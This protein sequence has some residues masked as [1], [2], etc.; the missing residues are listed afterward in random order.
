M[1]GATL[2]K[3]EQRIEAGQS[4]VIVWD[5][6]IPGRWQGKSPGTAATERVNRVAMHCASND[7]QNAAAGAHTGRGNT[8]VGA[9]PS[10][11]W[12]PMRPRPGHL[13][14]SF[15]GTYGA[16]TGGIRAFER[17]P[18]ACLEQ[19]IERWAPRTKLWD[20]IANSLPQLPVSLRTRQLPGDSNGGYRC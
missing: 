19:P 10:S 20:I 2:P 3:R 4:A 5:V 15:L 6:K 13:V 17:Y 12:K 18:F 8:E 14:V 7:L 16:D 9:A 1:N 11:R